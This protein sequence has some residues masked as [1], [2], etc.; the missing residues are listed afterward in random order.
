MKIAVTA[1]ELAVDGACAFV[2][3]MGALHA[4]HASLIKK[5]REYSDTVVVSIFINPLQ[6][7]NKDDLAKYPRTPEFDIELASQAGATHL[8]LPQSNEIYPDEVQKISAGALGNIYE[9]V[10]RPGHFDGVLTVVSRLFELVNPEW[11]IFGEKDFQQLTLIKSMK[12][13]VKIVAAP[14][15]RDVDGLALSSRNIRLSD[16]ES[17]LIIYRALVAAS[18]EINIDLA[19][20]IMKEVLATEES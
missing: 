10:N 20:F 18:K 1:K 6:F 8:W 7:E 9:G 4:G 13:K 14:T 3:T 17:A 5:A 12:S 15:I 16:R 11:A 19:R 2:P